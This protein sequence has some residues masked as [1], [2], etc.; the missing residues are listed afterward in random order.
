MTCQK[1]NNMWTGLILAEPRT[2]SFL[3]WL[4]AKVSVLCVQGRKNCEQTE[5]TKKMPYLFILAKMFEGSGA[6]GLI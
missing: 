1:N 5:D 4:A 3:F 6:C 2:H